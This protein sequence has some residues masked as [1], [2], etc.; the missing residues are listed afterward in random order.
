MTLIIVTGNDISELLQ[1]HK[2]AATFDIPV[3]STV[4]AA[5]V[6]YDQSTLLAGP[7]TMLST[8]DGAVWST[9]LVSLI[10][11]KSL[12]TSLSPAKVKIEV[13]VDDTDKE[14]WFYDAEIVEGNIA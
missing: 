12:T 11:D 1:L 6:S 13:S 14:S 7:F 5:I 9:S 8:D 4:K 3:A 2:N 10:V